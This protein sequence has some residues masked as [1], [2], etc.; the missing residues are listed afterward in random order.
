MAL[1]AQLLV[2]FGS[3]IGRTAFVR[4]G[5]DVHYLNLFLVLIGATAAGG[6]GM[7]WGRCRSVLA[8]VDADWCDNCVG[9]GIASGEGLIYALRDDRLDG[10]G[11]VLDAGQPEKRLLVLEPEWG[12]VMTI[13]AKDGNIVGPV[14]RN[15]TGIQATLARSRS[16]SPTTARRPICPSSGTSPRR[17]SRRG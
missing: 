16:K 14:L 5:A 13:A 6:K 3:L 17:R 1:L 7:S 2:G 9:G 8:R 11:N 10:D 12:R 15:F 4:I